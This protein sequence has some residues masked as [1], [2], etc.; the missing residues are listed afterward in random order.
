[1]ADIYDPA[2]R[3]EIMAKVKGRD[4]KP[5]MIVRRF[6]HRQGLRY[7]LHAKGIPGRPDLVFPS[8]RVVVFVHGCFWHQHPGCPKARLPATR[9]DFWQEKLSGNV[10][11]DQRNLHKLEEAGWTPIVIWECKIGQEGLQ[12]LYQR[13]IDIGDGAGGGT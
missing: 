2:K 10:S 9:T 3:S 12:E 6:L 1:M 13:I 5:E 8:R 7:R 11:R 4:T